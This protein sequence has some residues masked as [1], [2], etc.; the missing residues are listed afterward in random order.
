MSYLDDRL[1]RVSRETRMVK[2]RSIRELR[3][4]KE[5]LTAKRRVAELI[6][7]VIRVFTSHCGGVRRV[8]RCW[9]AIARPMKHIIMRVASDLSTVRTEG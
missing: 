9:S 1:V 5:A 8:L 3:G 7:S 4:C 6:R 2:Q